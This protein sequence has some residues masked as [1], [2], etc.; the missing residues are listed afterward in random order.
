MI[1]V[2]VSWCRDRVVIASDE[3]IHVSSLSRLEELFKISID[4]K[5]FVNS[6]FLSEDAENIES[7]H[8][9]AT[10]RRWNV[11]TGESIGKPMSGH[12]RKVNSVAIR[13]NLIVSGCDDGLVY[14][15]N[16]IIG[17]PIGSVL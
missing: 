10:V 12:S 9:D 15:W 13:G 11:N 5:A 6:V 4:F 8:D 3:G 1:D 14:R 7:G 17:E 2:A 16:E